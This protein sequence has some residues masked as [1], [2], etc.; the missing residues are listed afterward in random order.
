MAHA[1]CIIGLGY[2]DEGKGNTV[3]RLV[4]THRASHVVKT[5]G[6]QCAH[7]VVTG[8]GRHFTFS[9]FG[10]GTLAGAST[11]LS[12]NMLINPLFLKDEVRDL[13]AVGVT[14]PYSMLTVHRDAIVITPFQVAANRLRE[15]HRNR[16]RHGSCGHGINEAVSDALALGASLRA[17]DLSDP[18]ILKAKLQVSQNFK[19]G[20]IEPLMHDM[21][22]SEDIAREWDILT[23]PFNKVMEVY[24]EFVKKVQVVTD[25]Y[26]REVFAE[27][28]TVIF[29]NGQG[30]LLD[31][32]FGWFPYV[33]R[34]DTT[35]E[36]ALDLLQ[37]VQVD[38]PTTRL[39]VI[40]SYSTR[41]G[42]GPFV[43]EDA[44]LAHPEAHNQYG[45]WQQGFRQGHFDMIALDY[46]LRV[47]DGV[48]G[49]VLTHL[50]RV[51]GPQKV[52][53]AYEPGVNLALPETIPEQKQLMEALSQT[54]PC[55]EMVDDLVSEVEK[56][57]PVVLTSHGPTAGDFDVRRKPAQSGKAA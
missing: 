56:L 3:D 50:D 22:W 32:S 12:R 48:D 5:G 27:P 6:P 20:Q 36:P 33:T 55:Y 13:R 23:A 51:D 35:F 11:H 15:T 7:N 46:A 38:Y 37:D 14:N 19:R 24:S 43:T 26:L 34:R 41:H 17:K 4:R 8:D 16:G 52:C 49:I 21:G 47:V 10:S 9:Q 57:A 18:L 2:G 44:S 40:R 29:E 1:I 30:V 45:Q 28:G 39:G 31:E 42:A 25:D 54:K 53:M